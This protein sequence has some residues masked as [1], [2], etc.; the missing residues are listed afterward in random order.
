MGCRFINAPVP[1]FHK[2]EE[3][4]LFNRPQQRLSPGNGDLARLRMLVTSELASSQLF[5]HGFHIVVSGGVCSASVFSRPSL[6]RSGAAICTIPLRNSCCINRPCT[7]NPSISALNGASECGFATE[8][9]SLVASGQAFTNYMQK[10]T[11]IPLRLRI[12]PRRL[13]ATRP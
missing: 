4:T 2:M 3:R 11:K 1:S 9:S 12:G 7:D 5:I 6:A 8:R 13:Q 10:P